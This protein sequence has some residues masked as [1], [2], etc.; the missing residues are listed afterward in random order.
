M[1]LFKNRNVP[2][3]LIIFPHIA[4]SRI[5]V[6]LFKKQEGARHEWT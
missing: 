5:K 2:D 6:S 4:F 3:F 1:E